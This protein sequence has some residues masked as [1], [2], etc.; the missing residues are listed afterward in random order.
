M[1]AEWN[2]NCNIFPRK[3][4]LSKT[5]YGANINRDGVTERRLVT[6]EH[7]SGTSFVLV[8]WINPGG[9]WDTEGHCMLP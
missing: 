4:P 7:G 1:P 6:S 2:A 8:P 9:N 5:T 3:T